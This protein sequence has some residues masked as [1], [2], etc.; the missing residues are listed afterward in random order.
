MYLRLKF[1]SSVNHFNTT[2]STKPMSQWIREA[3]IGT[4]ALNALPSSAFD[5]SSCER[6][7]SLPD[8]ITVTSAVASGS[9]AAVA[10]G[11]YL[12]FSAAHSQN[13]N[14][15]SL[16]RIY[17]NNVTNQSFGP[18]ILTPNGLNE[19]P[20]TW[21]STQFWHSTT[22]TAYMQHG[23][24]DVEFQFFISA[25][26]VI[27]TT[28]DSVSRGGTAGLFQVE[29]TGADT[30]ARNLNNQYGAQFFITAHGRFWPAATATISSET[31]G[32]N[33]AAQVGI[34]MPQSY[35]GD[36]TFTNRGILTFGR[37]SQGSGSVNPWIW[38]DTST[39]LYPTRDDIG[40]TQN[41]MIP[42]YFD[43]PFRN[44]T[45]QAPG[46]RNALIGRVP[47]LWRTSDFAGQSGQAATVSGV[48][49]RFVRL[50]PVAISTSNVNAGVYMV[51]TTI[52]GV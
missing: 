42:V 31:E 27:W 37:P 17:Q 2:V 4:T 41:Y 24:R 35:N 3:I 21:S 34:Y 39:A 5:I 26:W 9:T 43:G 32:T 6:I 1:S 33:T 13:S 50:H 11:N 45:I 8:N 14:L 22:N 51:P 49:Y 7:G 16:F 40:D 38:P 23:L 46:G 44:T 19:L 36:G 18:R 12:Q 30:W 47:F 20:T 25:H 48:E 29:A 28:I 52:G 15:V 10:T